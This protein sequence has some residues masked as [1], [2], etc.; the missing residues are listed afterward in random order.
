[1]ILCNLICLFLLVELCV[2]T[3]V[4]FQHFLWAL[5]S[6]YVFKIFIYLMCVGVLSTCM[7]VYHVYAV[8]VEAREGTEF[9]AQ[10][11]H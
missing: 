7:S 4:Q 1:M 2:Q 6:L 10:R 5:F 9:P 3:L 11:G 8:P